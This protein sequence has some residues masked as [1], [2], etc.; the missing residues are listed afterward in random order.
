MAV[1]RA[2][3]QRE[4]IGASPWLGR[5]LRFRIQLPWYSTP[6]RQWRIREYPLDEEDR[7]F[8]TMKLGRWLGLRFN[9]R[10]I[11]AEVKEIMRHGCVSPGFVTTSAERHR[12]VV[13]YKIVNEHL[14]GW[15][16][17]MDQPRVIA[18]TL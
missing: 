2:Y 14:E 6:G 17:R 7:S 4:E 10:A 12:I 18:P 9:K 16:F 3:N 11:E 13:H 5:Q 15:T 8:V 1:G